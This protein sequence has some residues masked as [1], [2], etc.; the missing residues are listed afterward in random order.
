MAAAGG[1]HLQL[2]L[3]G[4]ASVSVIGPLF[5]LDAA[6]SWAVALLVV[7][8]RHRV[9][10]A[11]GVAIELGAITGLALASTTGLFGFHQGGGGVAGQ[12]AAAYATEGAAAA[13]LA[14]SLVLRQLQ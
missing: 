14:A 12:I 11:L 9:A 4:Y 5:L 1:I 2:W 6:A 10:A 8:T 7:L 3:S 13:L